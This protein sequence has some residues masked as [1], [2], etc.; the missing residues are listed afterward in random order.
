MDYESPKTR[1]RVTNLAVN[2]RPII[3]RGDVIESFIGAKNT[4]AREKLLNG[5]QK[6]VTFDIMGNSQYKIEVL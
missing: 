1:Y 6:V 4:E 3:V 5:S 2:N